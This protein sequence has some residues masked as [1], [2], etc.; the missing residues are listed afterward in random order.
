MAQQDYFVLIQSENNQ[1]FYARIGPRTY[2][3]SAQGHLIIPQLRDSTY[4]L[5]V[6]FPRK[7][8][9]EQEFPLVIYKKDLEFQLKNLGEK[10]WGL[11]NPRT[12]EL[13]TGAV[14]DT[15]DPRSRVEGVKKDDAFSRMMA[16][17]VSDTAVMYAKAPPVDTA[18]TVAV[19][20]VDPPKDSVKGGSN[21][22]AKGALS[23]QTRKTS[24]IEKLEEEKTGTALRLLYTERS[25]GYKT[26]TI[27]V[28]IALQDSAVQTS[29]PRLTPVKS[30]CKDLASDYDVDKL[31]I[32][33]LSANKLDEKIGEARKVFDTK[34]FSTKQIKALSEVFVA[35]AAKYRF[36]E[37]ARPFVSD[38]HFGEL[39]VLFTEPAYISK[40]KA[41]AGG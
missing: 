31:R 16:G 21:D 41:L 15:V 26:D 20:M 6:G 38:E 32:R 4:K 10:G 33:M 27:Q 25:K 14:K 1:P 7:I 28:L 35:Q 18:K 12:L 30:D 13:K 37:T 39:S 40:F 8:F 3:S 9:P 34:C 23:K 19:I 17:I 2:S 5:L 22:S 24:V 36:L 11:F 29:H